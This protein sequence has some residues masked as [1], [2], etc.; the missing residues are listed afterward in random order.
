MDF[1]D[2]G[3]GDAHV[4]IEFKVIDELALRGGVVLA[5]EF[6]NFYFTAGA[7]INVAGL[8]VDAAYILNETLGNTLILSAEFSLG[9][10][11]GEEEE[12]GIE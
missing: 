4:G 7:G 3:M 10:L 8:Y 12:P 11:L 2:A 5:D 6:Q 1:N 9:S